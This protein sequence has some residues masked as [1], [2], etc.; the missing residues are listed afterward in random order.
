MQI[1]APVNVAITAQ[2]HVSI[3]HRLIWYSF[4]QAQSSWL[5][6]FN[7]RIRQCSRNKTYA[8]HTIAA[9]PSLFFQ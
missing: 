7:A 8:A 5:E 9:Q 2:N 4:C 3:G 6:M 1:L